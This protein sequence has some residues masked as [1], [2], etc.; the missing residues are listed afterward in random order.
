MEKNR[1]DYSST[2]YKGYLIKVTIKCNKCGHIFKQTPKQHLKGVGCIKCR[3][4][5]RISILQTFIKK[6]EKVHDKDRYDYSLSV[7]NHS[8]K[9][10]IIKCNKCNYIFKQA[11]YAHLS[12]RGCPNCAIAIQ[13]SKGEK[14][15]C[16]Y[17]KSLYSGEILENTRKFIGGKELDIYLPELKLAFEYN[18]EYWHQFHEE[19][20]PGYHKNKRKAC[21]EN[22]IKL[23]EV[24]ENDWKKN[25]QQIKDLISKH[26]QI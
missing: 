22:G 2:L 18:G 4:L 5:N 15:L 26:L 25:N 20:E 17:I 24:W 6:A 16:Q 7:Y 12:G 1:F 19:K 3:N 21:K 8:H 10:I 11:P 9:K 14:E 13:R 23:I